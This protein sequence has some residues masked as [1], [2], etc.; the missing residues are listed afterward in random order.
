MRAIE[1]VIAVF[2]AAVAFVGVKLMGLV[3][4]IALVAAVAGLAMGFVIARAFRPSEQ[5]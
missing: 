4:Q 2:L 5:A 1:F 3:L